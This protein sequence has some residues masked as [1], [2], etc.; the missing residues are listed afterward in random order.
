MDCIKD[1]YTR[2]KHIFITLMAAD[3]YPFIGWIDFCNFCKVVGIY[4]SVITAPVVD[5][6]FFATKF[7]PQPGGEGR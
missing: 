7:N 4:D 6:M 1:N 2:I 3:Q 5:N